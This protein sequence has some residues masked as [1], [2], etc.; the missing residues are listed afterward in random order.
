MGH[1]CAGKKKP[2]FIFDF[3][4]EIL[5]L[6]G[7]SEDVMANNSE[8]TPEEGRVIK[9]LADAWNAFVALPAEHSS[10]RVDFASII[11][12]GQRMIMAR[13]TRRAAG[14]AMGLRDKP[15]PT[16]GWESNG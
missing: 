4:F 10:E 5:D 14:W 6:K 3:R 11:H 16:T 15:Y 8:L 9:L 2:N 7:E 1:P 12:Q 13:P